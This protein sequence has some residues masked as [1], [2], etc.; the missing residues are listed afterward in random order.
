M[1]L[2]MYTYMHIHTRW[3][4]TPILILIS[5]LQTIIFIATTT[6]GRAEK[7]VEILQA[8]LTR[9]RIKRSVQKET[10]PIRNSRAITSGN[11]S[12]NSVTLPDIISSVTSDAVASIGI[13]GT[14]DD[15]DDA[16]PIAALI[17]VT[18]ANN[19]EEVLI[20]STVISEAAASISIART[21]D[22]ADN[23]DLTDRSVDVIN[24]D[25]RPLS[26]V[27]LNNDAV[28][29]SSLLTSTVDLD[30][31][32]D[33]INGDEITT[34]DP[35]N[36]TTPSI[37]TKTKINS[38]ADTTLSKATGLDKTYDIV[39]S[40][41]GSVNNSSIFTATSVNKKMNVDLVNSSPGDGNDTIETV[42]MKTIV[43]IVDPSLMDMRDINDTVR[44][45]DDIVNSRT[46]IDVE[47][48]C[49]IN[50]MDIDN[51]ANT[52]MQVDAFN[53]SLMDVRGILDLTAKQCDYP[54]YHNEEIVRTST[55]EPLYYQ[56]EIVRVS[57]EGPL[58]S[59][60]SS[61]RKDDNEF[62]SFQETIR[63]LL[64]LISFH[65]S[66]GVGGLFDKNREFKRVFVN[67]T[68][69][70]IV[71]LGVFI[72]IYIC[73][74]V[75]V[76]L[77]IY[78]YVC[79]CTYLYICIHLYI[80]MHICSYISIHIY[81]Y[82]EFALTKLGWD[83]FLKEKCPKQYKERFGAFSAHHA[84]SSLEEGLKWVRL[85]YLEYVLSYQR[86]KLRE[87]DLDVYIQSST[88]RNI[89]QF[90]RKRISDSSRQT[91]D[92]SYRS[93]E[94][95]DPENNSSSENS[96]IPTFIES[97]IDINDNGK[98]NFDTLSLHCSNYMHVFQSL[99]HIICY[100]AAVLWFAKVQ[101]EAYRLMSNFGDPVER[102][103]EVCVC[104]YIFIYIYLCVCIY[105]YVN[106]Y[107]CTYIH[108]YVHADWCLISMIQ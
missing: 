79:I 99:K 9:Q 37:N 68:Y 85:I 42:N 18:T 15:P 2:C 26:I 100:D 64:R 61:K 8:I 13:A 98:R 92:C 31:T 62:E 57:T 75:C 3:Y 83:S 59:S 80:Y 19:S 49:E 78:E 102:Y 45:V 105:T 95:Y 104:V 54:A 22:N 34:T 89:E 24:K 58:N 12:A 91:Y 52:K 39:H 38:V 73:I 51:T 90:N 40:N 77:Q 32:Y 41:K 7:S 60:P 97:E 96:L 67:D 71:T 88:S 28:A 93:D 4:S 21:D 29:D 63:C 43:D 14:D 66:I 36:I 16:N 6:L 65:L 53:S 69:K 30:K 20:I 84:N 11:N 74:Y 50:E 1:Y 101:N 86:K 35:V 103:T 82:S 56:D 44:D 55:L 70:T 94:S 10:F 106:E 25:L 33:I 17:Q 87:H 47:K 46:E 27:L 76:Y 107:I 23:I 5:K 108:I 81:K 72:F 48:P